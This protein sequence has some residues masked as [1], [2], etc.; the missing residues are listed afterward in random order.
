MKIRLFAVF[1]AIVLL[2]TLSACSGDAP[3]A[4]V[5]TKDQVNKPT[6][7]TTTTTKATTTEAIDSSNTSQNDQTNASQTG[8]TTLPS[9]GT[10]EGNSETG[11]A[12]ANLAISLIGTPFVNNGTAPDA[13][14]NPSFVV[15]CYKQNGYTVPRKATQ[16][17]D[18]GFDVNPEE[19]QPGDILVFCN[20]PGE[21]AGF[22]AIYIGNNQ[23][24]ASTNPEKGTQVHQLN[25]SY[26]SQRFLSAR[27]FQ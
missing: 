3:Q 13:F 6:V 18:Y 26:W 23:F 10:E 24:V 14:D 4:T 2:V 12:I 7:T 22:V 5:I 21:E 9:I 1:T 17:I 11:D 25:S 19:I 15:Y 20:N 27:R 8:T 16:I